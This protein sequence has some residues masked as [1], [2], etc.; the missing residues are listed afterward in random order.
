MG[1]HKRR[2]RRPDLFATLAAAEATLKCLFRRH[3]KAARD[4]SD[5]AHL[6]VISDDDGD[7]YLEQLSRMSH[8]CICANARVSRAQYFNN[9]PR[10]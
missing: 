9:D 8:W 1:V 5:R 7:V 6:A 3:D 2:E 10:N 4:A